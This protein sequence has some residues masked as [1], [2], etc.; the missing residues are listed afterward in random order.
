MATISEEGGDNCEQH[1]RLE[2][3]TAITSGKQ[4]NAQEELK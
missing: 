4:R 2:L 1:W 3:R